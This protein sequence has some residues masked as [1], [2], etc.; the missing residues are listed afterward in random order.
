MWREGSVAKFCSRSGVLQ[1]RR[2]LAVEGLVDGVAGGTA[3]LAFP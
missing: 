2:V 3:S 1:E